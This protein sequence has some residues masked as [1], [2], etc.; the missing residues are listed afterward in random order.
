MKYGRAEGGNHDRKSYGSYGD[1]RDAPHV[2]GGPL[3]HLPGVGDAMSS[4]KRV[5]LAVVG[6]GRVGQV[7][8]E[9][10]SS[11]HDLSVGAIVRRAATA[12]GRLPETLRAIPVVT[13]I[14]L[15]K[16]VR[17]A[18]ICVPTNMVAEMA[19]QSLR[20]GIPAVD[21]VTLHGEAFQVHKQAM[22]K[23]AIRHKVPAIVGAGWDPG[24]LSVFRSWFALLMPGGAT[25]LTHRPGAGLHHTAMAQGVAG[26]KDALCAEVHKAD[27]R[28][29][30]YVYVELEDGAKADRVAEAIQADPLFVGEEVQVFVVESVASL[31]K[32]RGVVLD[33]RSHPGWI[34]HHHVLL[35]ARVDDSILTAQVMLTAAR[36]L[37]RLEP[38]AYALPDV[39]LTALWGEDAD[40]AE[41]DWA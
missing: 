13:H 3:E 34:G 24:A 31:E 40:K 21:C 6:F 25:E 14:G 27:G 41:R 23:L 20:Q 39:P 38:G 15:A 2:S 12:G 19:A 1:N 22:H 16:D 8:A 32:G 18:L 11:S 5:N 37:T 35:E 4:V 10:I 30:R 9:L 26:V 17:A 33:R 36:A 7:C 28:R 29:Q